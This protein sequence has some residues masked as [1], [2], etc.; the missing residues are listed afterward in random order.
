M[1]RVSNLRPAEFD[2]N[3]RR[4]FG[5]K[6]QSAIGFIAIPKTQRLPNAV[7]VRAFLGHQDLHA[8]AWKAPRNVKTHRRVYTGDQK[9]IGPQLCYK[10]DAMPSLVPG[11]RRPSYC[12]K[13]NN[14]VACHA[15]KSRSCCD[16]PNSSIDVFSLPSKFS[17]AI[18]RL[19]GASKAKL[20]AWPAAALSPR[21]FQPRGST[22]NGAIPRAPSPSARK[23]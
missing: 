22:P 9:L 13:P 20:R 7:L 23:S 6:V 19:M 18:S 16:F 8:H 15:P 17:L 21:M 10:R 5:M 2:S 1:Q 3:C 11:G 4:I 14:T 12:G